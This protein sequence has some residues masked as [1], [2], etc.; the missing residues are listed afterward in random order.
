M[1]TPVTAAMNTNLRLMAPLHKSH[2]QSEAVSN[3]ADAANS[4]N[5]LLPAHRAP[6]HLI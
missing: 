5:H 3:R 4:G 1:G 6:D 2:K